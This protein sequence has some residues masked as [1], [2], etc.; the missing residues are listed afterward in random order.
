[1]YESISEVLKSGSTYLISSCGNGQVIDSKSATAPYTN[2][3][4]AIEKVAK[5]AIFTI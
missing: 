3:L 4:L 5:F 1:M 2:L